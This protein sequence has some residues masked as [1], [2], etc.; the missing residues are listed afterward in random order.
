MH[1]EDNYLFVWKNKRIDLTPKENEILKV[2]IKN[3]GKWTE[4]NSIC[5]LLYGLVSYSLYNST[6]Q[7]MHRLKRKL[8]KKVEILSYKNKGYMIGKYFK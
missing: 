8:R 5:E 2:L 7:V 1:D 6:Y 3:K 4:L